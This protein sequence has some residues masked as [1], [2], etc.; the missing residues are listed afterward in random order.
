MRHTRAHI[1]TQTHALA[2]AYA[3]ITHA[4]TQ[5]YA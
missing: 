4:Y 1:H 3:P 5:K 2:R